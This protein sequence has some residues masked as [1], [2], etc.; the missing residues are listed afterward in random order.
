M[1]RLVQ[2]VLHGMT[3]PL[4]SRIGLPFRKTII[5][6]RKSLPSNIESFTRCLHLQKGTPPPF[7]KLSACSTDPR[8]SAFRYRNDVHYSTYRK[9]F[10]SRRTLTLLRPDM[11]RPVKVA[12]DESVDLPLFYHA[13]LSSD[14]YKVNWERITRCE[15]RRNGRLNRECK[16][17][18]L[19]SK[20]ACAYRPALQ[21]SFGF[22]AIRFQDVCTMRNMEAPSGQSATFPSM[23][24]L[25]ELAIL[26][27][28][29]HQWMANTW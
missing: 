10:K 1:H 26:R 24:L 19:T 7:I 27:K 13:E 21:M 3:A 5:L 2:S 22:S 15:N 17:S 25:N 20:S 4:T 11:F 28:M 23:A 12:I 16:S 9:W 18:T 29:M 14:I 6:M 8:I